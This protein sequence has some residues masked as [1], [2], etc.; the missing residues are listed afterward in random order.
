MAIPFGY[1]YDFSPMKTTNKPGGTRELLDKIPN[2]PCLYRHRENNSYYGIKKIGGKIK[3]RALDTADRA[4]ANR[5]LAE[6][7]KEL[8]ETDAGKADLT[9]AGLFARYA[10]TR[11]GKKEHTRANDASV[12]KLFASSFKPGMDVLVSRVR[13]SDLATCLATMGQNLRNRSFN[14]YRDI[15]AKVFH[16]AVI[17]RVIPAPGPFSDDL[18]PRRK[19]QSVTRNIPTQAE[20][21]KLVASMRA[22]RNNPDAD[23]CADFAEFQG[24]AGVGQAEASAI[25]WED[26]D[27]T[28]NRIHYVRVKTERPFST[29]IYAWL[30][31][32]LERRRKAAGENPKGRIFAIQGCAL[33]L[34]RAAKRLGFP[35]LSQRNLRSMR[36]VAMLDAGVDVK[37]V[38]EWQGHRDGGKLI[39]D[40]Y[41]D[42][43]RSNQNEYEAQQLARAEGKLVRF[44]AAA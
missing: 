35:H 28:A 10:E 7:L 16:L 20:F 42:V 1:T 6:W 26:V 14:L 39:L 4:S 41:S 12:R 30:R 37:Q 40:T 11:A 19:K 34:A 32:L 27:F 21:E 44:A 36:I 18:I 33:S 25:I 13:P 43:I 24:L 17:D 3:T 29:P 9:V 5:K 8:A 38:A 31:P 23:E 15:V 2:A 22:Q